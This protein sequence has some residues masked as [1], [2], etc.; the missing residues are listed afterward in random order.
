MTDPISPDPTGNP[1]PVQN[2][3]TPAAE[4]FNAAEDEPAEEPADADQDSFE[5]N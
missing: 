4:V 5:S 3:P 1:F 2:P